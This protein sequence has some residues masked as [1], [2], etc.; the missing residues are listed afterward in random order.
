MTKLSLAGALT[1][2]LLALSAP[3]AFAGDNNLATLDAGS[4]RSDAVNVTVRSDRAAITAPQLKVRRTP[5][6]AP[7][8]QGSNEATQYGASY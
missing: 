1:A 3:A 5:L 6:L 8:F 7:N 2:T 4:G